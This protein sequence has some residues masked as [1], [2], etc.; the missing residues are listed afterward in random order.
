MA[1]D[2]IGG[3]HSQLERLAAEQAALRRIA[4]LVAREAPQA[5]V[6]SA[7]A[8]EIGRLLG[9]DEMR[10]LRYDSDL[11]AVVVANAGDR[12]AFHIGSRQSASGDNVASV[13]LR[14]GRTARSDYGTV[15]SAP[16]EAG[17]SI[18][19]RSEVAAPI[20]VGSR[21]WGAMIA[22]TTSD[23]ALPAD[24]ES[25]LNQF[26]ELMA[27]A[28]ANTE[29]HAKAERLADEQAALRRVATLVAEGDSPTAVF[30]AVA[31]EVERLLDADGVTLGRYEPA[32]QVTVVAYRRGPEA[33]CVPPGRRI[34]H[35]GENVTTIVRRTQRPARIDYSMAVRGVIAD[36]TRGRGIRA[37]IAAPIFVEGRLWGVISAAWS[38]QESPPI[39]IKDR[40]AQFAQLLGT[41]IANAD[42]RDQ[43]TASRARVLAAADE[44]RRRIARDLHDGAQ[45]RLVVAALTLKRIQEVLVGN[46]GTAD[47]L[48]G[49]AIEQVE[50]A[51]VELRE[52][53]RGMLPRELTAGGL[54]AAV[55]TF[56]RRLDI[57][58]QVDI[59]TQ[60]FPPGIEASAYFIVTEALTNVVKHARA[61]QA[62]VHVSAADGMLRV[63]VRDD[64]IGGAD[65][66][67]HGLVG[68]GDRA[69]TFGGWLD[70]E[71]PPGDGTRVTATLPLPDASTTT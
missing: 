11:T 49:D 53:A 5:E 1:R 62:D 13:V 56:A 22:G 19:I 35:E 27:T 54:C 63:E 37:A 59:P 14:T 70:I 16:A 15:D 47:S 69:I 23:D 64:G 41:A 34:S 66:R 20:L 30:D 68:L 29:S 8:E 60:R 50:R 4:T 71:S 67:G 17:R 28:I 26:T 39:G 40:M 18:G 9:T 33:Q 7:I 52:L 3:S 36:M 21:V 12:D 24:T 2:V 10:M 46:E 48:I 61:T 43:L 25:R 44:A 58:V 51:N 57:P 45:Q 32:E 55:R 65:P 38:G 42:S 31:A 6:F